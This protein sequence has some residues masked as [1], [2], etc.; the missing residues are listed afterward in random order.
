MIESLI[1]ELYFN[2]ELYDSIE[3][4]TAIRIGEHYNGSSC[5]I[6]RNGTQIIGQLETNISFSGSL[7][8]LNNPS[9][10]QWVR[11]L[12]NELVGRQLQISGSIIY[13]NEDAYHAVRGDAQFGIKSQYTMDYP[14]GEEFTAS[15]VPT[16]LSDSAPIGSKLTSSFSLV[17][18]G[19]VAHISI[20]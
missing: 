19:A 13:T 4:G 9:V 17:S 15:F 11:Y 2:V 12:N 3:L 10:D 6:K 20:E 14:S 8:Q 5:V 16:N 7:I 1:G 18:S